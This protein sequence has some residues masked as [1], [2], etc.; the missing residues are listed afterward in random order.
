[1]C[2]SYQDPPLSTLGQGQVQISSEVQPGIRIIIDHQH[3]WSQPVEEG[4]IVFDNW[5]SYMSGHE[6]TPPQH[7]WIH[8]SR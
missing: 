2:T 7:Y 1:M 4:I 8:W 3:L 6:M 5:S